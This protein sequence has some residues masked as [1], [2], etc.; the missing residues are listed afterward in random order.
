MSQDVYQPCACGSG[1]KYKFCCMPV[2]RVIEQAEAALEKRRPQEA[3]QL[4]ESS[5]KARKYSPYLAVLHAAALEQAGR[6]AESVEILEEALQQYGEHPYLLFRLLLNVVRGDVRNAE[7]VEMVEAIAQ[8]ALLA[9]AA[10]AAN[11]ITPICLTMAAFQAR[12]SRWLS[13]TAY[14]A[15]AAAFAATQQDAVRALRQMQQAEQRIR[16]PL[17]AELL[18]PRLHIRS[19]DP[20]LREALETANRLTRLACYA[21]AAAT[22]AEALQKAPENFELLAALVRLHVLSGRFE[23]ACSAADR[24]IENAQTDE[25]RVAGHLTRQL[26]RYAHDVDLVTVPHELL[27][28]RDPALFLSRVDDWPQAVLMQMG[29]PP[30]GSSGEA[31]PRSYLL[32]REAVAEK[33]TGD[34]RVLFLERPELYAGTMVVS[35][36]ADLGELL[37]ASGHEPPAWLRETRHMTVIVRV[38][39][40]EDLPPLLEKLKQL[41]EDCIVADRSET[42]GA[43][44]T[45]PA[46][47]AE[48]LQR[49]KSG[50]TEIGLLTPVVS[51][52]PETASLEP[53]PSPVGLTDDQLQQWRNGW[54]RIVRRWR[55]TPLPVLGWRTPAEV[56]DASAESPELRAAA[57][58]AYELLPP[59]PSRIELFQMLEVPELPSVTDVTDDELAA[60][61]SAATRFLATLVDPNALADDQLLALVQEQSVF[62]FFEWELPQ[63]V[64]GRDEIRSR[65]PQLT[66][67]LLAALVQHAAERGQIERARQW[68][69]EA[70]TLT[71][72]LFRSALQTAS[73]AEELSPVLERVLA[74]CTSGLSLLLR[75]PRTE[76]DAA[77]AFV[78]W[79]RERFVTKVPELAVPIAQHLAAQGAAD[80]AA[81]LTPSRE[82]AAAPAGRVSSSSGLWT[83]DAPSGGGGGKIWVPGQD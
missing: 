80:L 31:A 69:E 27:L 82:P 64:V 35:P 5:R 3:L 65:N 76:R 22:I 79:V 54:E 18:D 62:R 11:L 77:V 13:A 53:L 70:Q 51:V 58:M 43:E 20:Q 47:V 33:P 15:T 73:R 48:T 66:V 45:A 59:G 26:V 42:D 72:E 30:A 34:P 63:A 6:A 7:V 38:R 16:P 19:D 1:K 74:V 4:I 52:L 50:L 9:A 36:P 12:R 10:N 60:R 83:P 61:L 24:L 28:V 49:V 23:E 67:A 29:Q 40:A 46:S 81:L 78:Q 55:E 41:G 71:E 37:E 68:L 75:R 32:L 44:A 21:A 8:H 39:D 25:Q 2:A 57:Y 14:S 17:A 56:Q